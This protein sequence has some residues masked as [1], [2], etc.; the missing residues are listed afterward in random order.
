MRIKTIVIIG[1]VVGFI[2]T[3]SLQFSAAID[4]PHN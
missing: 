1:L 4:A 2:I 3:I